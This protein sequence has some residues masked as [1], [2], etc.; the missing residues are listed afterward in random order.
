LSNISEKFRNKRSLRK[1]DFVFNHLDTSKITGKVTL[2]MYLKETISDVYYRKNPESKKEVITGDKMTG[3]GGYVD[4][5][6]IKLYLEALYQE[7]NFYD[8][9]ILLLA[10]QF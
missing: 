7:V 6:G 10:K 5:N 8:N 9:N 4:N 1:F 3:L 2:P